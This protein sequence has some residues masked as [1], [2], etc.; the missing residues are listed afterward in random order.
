MEKIVEVL[1]KLLD[2]KKHKCDNSCKYYQIAFEHRDRV[3]VLSDVFSVKKGELCSTYEKKEVK[4][5]E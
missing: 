5:N 2:V 1:D 4:V 3:C